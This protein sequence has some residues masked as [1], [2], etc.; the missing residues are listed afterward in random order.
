LDFI[1]VDP[2]EL[3][4]PSV[5]AY[6]SAPGRKVVIGMELARSVG[7][8]NYVDMGVADWRLLAKLAIECGWRSVKRDRVQV[9]QPAL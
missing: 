5:A 4:R 6:L 3:W 8:S 1:T 2:H 7:R 9:W